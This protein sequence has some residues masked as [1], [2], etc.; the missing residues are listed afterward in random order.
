VSTYS[1]TFRALR[2]TTD[3]VTVRRGH[4]DLRRGIR[5]GLGAAVPLAVGVL[6]GR[7]DLGVFAAL[8]ALPAGFAATTGA[9]ARQHAGAVLLS[10]L[11]MAGAG[12]AGAALADRSWLVLAALAA[13][14]YAAG[15]CSAFSPRIGIA[16]LQW[17]VALL[18]GT[19]APSGVAHAATYAALLLAGGS[20]QAL[21]TALDTR[22]EAPS[23][24][25][26]RNSVTA[27]KF[28]T[29]KNPLIVKNLLTATNPGTAG[30]GGRTVRRVCAT[31]R[32]GLDPRSEHGQHVLRLTVVAAATHAI[33]LAAGLSHGYWAALTALL[34]LKPEHTVTIR[35]SLDRIGGTAF[36]VVLGVPLAGVG[37]IGH[38]PLLLVAACTLCLAYTV[39]TA[40]YFV[41]CVFLTGFVVLLLDL[42]GESAAD[43]AL[44]RLAAT[45]V[46]GAI[47]LAASHIRP[48]SVPAPVR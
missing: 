11:G 32:A 21:L 17:P 16:T 38:G 20:W 13:A 5:L 18:L 33:A 19:S 15:L 45:V 39:Y 8:G 1:E 30:R 14:T 9:R 12:F 7:V 23:P 24:A 10:A 43:T 27:R 36:G 40:N 29:A 35:R 37:A 47:A 34:V 48:T 3:V 25:G 22:G 31:L 28:A 4:L 44:S 42:L 41:Y 6:L 26:P 2:P 46:G